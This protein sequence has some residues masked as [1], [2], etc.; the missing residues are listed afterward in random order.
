[1]YRVPS[2]DDLTN[3]QFYQKRYQQGFTTEVPTEGTLKQLLATKFSETE[4]CYRG[5]LSVLQELGLEPGARIFDYGCSWG[6]GSWQLMDYGYRVSA[7][8]ISKQRAEF[9]RAKLGIDCSSDVSAGLFK[10]FLRNSFDGFFSA[11][12]LEHV[13]SPSRVI[14]FAKLALR[15]GG[16]FVAFTPNGSEA[17]RRAD[18]NAWHLLWGR[19]HPNFIDDQFYRAAFPASA[20]YLDTCPVNLNLLARFRRGELVPSRELSGSELLCVVQL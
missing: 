13:P 8:E 16:V 5:Y 3:T 20:L 7:C 15:S 6:Y 1:M 18:P 9:A 14:D 4:K 12:V 19:V 10:G 2:D 11:H 17:F